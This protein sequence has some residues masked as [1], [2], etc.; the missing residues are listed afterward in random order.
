M[1][2]HKRKPL[3][4]PIVRAGHAGSCYI[5][6][7]MIVHGDKIRIVTDTTY[8]PPFQKACHAECY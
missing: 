7:Q 5:C 8:N 4:P 3:K 6:G 1:I 2:I